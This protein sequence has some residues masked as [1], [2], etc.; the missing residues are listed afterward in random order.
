MAPVILELDRRPGFEPI[1][2]ST[3][4]H[5]EM[6]LGT[7]STFGLEPD[8][9]LTMPR[10]RDTLA[11]MTAAAI[12]SIEDVLVDLGAVDWLV[13]QG[14]TTSA[15]AAGLAGF[16]AGV[17]VGHVEAGLR[18]GNLTSPFPEE[19]N[20]RILGG[21]ASCH[22]SPTDRATE[23]L[24]SENV[25]A[26]RIFQT[27]NTVID[28][29]HYVTGLGPTE[30]AIELLEPLNRRRVILLTAHRRENWDRLG[31]VFDAVEEIVERHPDVAFI[32]PVHSNPKV[33]QMANRLTSNSNVV[34]T[35][36]LAYRE[37]ASVLDSCTMVLT[38][39]GG[40]QEEAPALGKPVLVM[41]DE[42]ERPEAIE[43]GVAKL[44]GLDADTI[45]SEVTA[46]LTDT[47]LYASMSA[48]ANPFGDGTAAA[49]IVDALEGLS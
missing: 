43:A 15:M 19:V 41:R 33:G 44:V 12:T 25:D 36:P 30:E 17:A 18:S 32:Y 39:S 27:G 46:L 26:R 20:R 9:E 29:L 28:A 21:I 24:L 38:D 6:L 34:L 7:L 14:D 35:K 48:G 22:F 10:V 3:G 40:L 37:L 2:V 8:I 49:K 47:Q 4:Q 23:A 16:Y 11:G 45:V 1:V 13:V 31:N 5:R 42:T